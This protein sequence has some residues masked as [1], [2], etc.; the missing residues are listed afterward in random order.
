MPS[1]SFFSPVDARAVSG[2]RLDHETLPPIRNAALGLCLIA[3]P[4]AT[5]ISSLSKHSRRWWTN[6]TLLPVF[7]HIMYNSILPPIFLLFPGRLGRPPA[8]LLGVSSTL[9]ISTSFSSSTAI[10]TEHSKYGMTSFH[11]KSMESRLRTLSGGN[12]T[13]S[14]RGYTGLWKGCGFN[15][16]FNGWYPAGSAFSF[17]LSAINRWDLPFCSLTF[18]CTSPSSLTLLLTWCFL[19]GSSFSYHLF[20]VFWS[21]CN[22]R[23]LH[24]VCTA[25]V[26]CVGWTCERLF[27]LVTY[28]FFPAWLPPSPF[29][30]SSLSTSLVTQVAM[31]MEA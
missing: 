9:L 2:L 31:W 12:L 26:H 8:L 27:C 6:E 19:H 24:Y 28:C 30:P 21:S 4:F 25:C 17:G 16:Y 22:G 20:S 23:V 3:P 11:W 29:S 18:I 10:S 13:R 7:F 14:D 15:Y 5:T 1:P